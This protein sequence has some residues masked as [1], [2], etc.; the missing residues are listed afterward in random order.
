M[1]ILAWLLLAVRQHAVFNLF[2][3]IRS[4]D[5]DT[6]RGGSWIRSIRKSVAGTNANSRLAAVARTRYCYKM[7]WSIWSF[8]LI[9][10]IN[11]THKESEVQVWK[12]LGKCLTSPTPVSLEVFILARLLLLISRECYNINSQRCKERPFPRGRHGSFG[13]EKRMLRLKSFTFRW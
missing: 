7:S 12:S 4:C 5:R 2:W 6:S 1:S 9:C 11:Y 10:L 13:I 3:L 8:S